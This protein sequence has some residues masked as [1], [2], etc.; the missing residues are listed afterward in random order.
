MLEPKF[1]FVFGMMVTNNKNTWTGAEVG[2]W[3]GS[4]GRESDESSDAHFRLGMLEV[5]SA[6]TEERRDETVSRMMK[7]IIVFEKRNINGCE[8]RVAVKI[9]WELWIEAN[10][11]WRRDVIVGG[12][13]WWEYNWGFGFGKTEERETRGMN[14]VKLLHCTWNHGIVH[15]PENVMMLNILKLIHCTWCRWTFF[16]LFLWTSDDHTLY[17]SQ[18]ILIFFAKQNMHSIWVDFLFTYGCGEVGM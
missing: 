10:G 8:K 13:A 17:F 5:W 4:G 16:L 7:W 11:D 9:T 14:V 18:L 15:S 3:E 12:E 1:G 6:E 2:I